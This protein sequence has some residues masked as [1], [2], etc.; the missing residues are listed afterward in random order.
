MGALRN[1]R[2]W[3][4]VV[5]SLLCLWLAFRDVTVPD[6]G[7]ALAG[8]RYF[9]LFPAFGLQILA[10]VIRAVR[11]DVLLNR[12]GGVR[13]AFWAQGVGFL[14]TNIFPLRLGEPARVM[15][16]ADRSGLPWVRV[17]VSAAVER[18]LDVAAVLVLLGLVL[19]WMKAPAVVLLTG[20]S[21]GFLVLLALV[22]VGV[23]L[24]FRQASEKV[25]ASVAERIAVLPTEGTLRRW[26]ELLDGLAPLARLRVSL[27]SALGSA[28]IW[29]LYTGVYW[30]VLHAARPDSTTIEAA[31]MV[32]ALALVYTVPSSPGFIGVFQLVGQQALV[33]PFGDK[34]DARAA[35]AVTM[36]AYLVYY[37][38]TSL[39]GV[40]GLWRT[41]E[42]FVRLGRSSFRQKTR[43]R[44]AWHE[45][46]NAPEDP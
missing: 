11:W 5:V 9:W 38:T 41:G 24:R 25:V 32:V 15:V 1:R 34:Y 2:L 26:R 6:L 21:F 31:F 42:S 16:M 36:A 17:A 28:C 44:T 23:V 35:L 39:I 27:E 18:L 46:L 37:S 22:G 29:G 19:P 20:R 8:F 33:L 7:R 4:G 14:F 3:V 45:P 12:D 43:S 10:I 13:N 30:C 40:L